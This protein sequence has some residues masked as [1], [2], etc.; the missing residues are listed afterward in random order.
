MKAVLYIENAKKFFKDLDFT[1]KDVEKAC[2]EALPFAASTFAKIASDQ[3]YPD[4]RKLNSKKPSLSS[5]ISPISEHPYYRTVIDLR[6]L[7]SK[8]GIGRMHATKEDYE[9]L[10]KG[11]K[12]KVLNGNKMTSSSWKHFY[13]K[14][15]QEAIA[16]AKIHARA[17]AKAQWG[18]KLQEIGAKI[19][20][21]IASL[22]KK[23][24]TRRVE[25]SADIEGKGT[26][27]QSVN[28]SNTSSYLD[29]VC[30]ANVEKIAEPYVKKTIIAQVY[31]RLQYDKNL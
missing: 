31:K 23:L 5:P 18:A 1:Q 20:S 24:D 21:G 22:M 9:A 30:K 17:F 11:M 2:L 12:Y 10:R 29:K 6:A 28:I 19:P 3:T 16:K 25:G 14:T 26:S 15:K 4:K 8:A 13:A 7:C 27:I